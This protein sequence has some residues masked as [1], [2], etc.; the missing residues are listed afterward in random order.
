MRKLSL[1]ALIWVTATIGCN[2][3]QNL[4]DE[5]VQTALKSNEARVAQDP[6]NPQAHSELAKAY[7]RA[8]LSMKAA[9][10]HLKVVELDPKNSDSIGALGRI[11]QKLG[12]YTAAYRQLT[13][14]LKIDPKHSECL[15]RLGALLRKDGSKAG[16][17]QSLT[18]W[19]QFLRVTQNHPKLDEVRRTVQEVEAQLETT[20]GTSGTEASK[21]APT[22]SNP[23]DV[24]PSHNQA[25]SN[26]DVGQ[27]NPF[28]AAIGKAIA[29]IRRKDS[30][31]AENAFRDALKI[32][33]NDAGALAGLAET[34][35]HQ[36]KSPEAQEAVTKAYD[37]DPKNTQ[38]QWVYGLIMIKSGKNI[39]RALQAWTT[40]N[41]ESPEFAKQVGVTKTLETVQKMKAPKVH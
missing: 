27:L 38:A 28:G 16:L 22:P 4:I 30:L 12:Y 33:P 29:A 7:D 13:H 41:R 34:L 24:I 19:R 17:A 3:D 8:G 2:F 5:A 31:A 37:A 14:C 1:G 18:Y 32:R 10:A 23:S 26:E 25:G 35:F 11:Y 20:A 15:Y 9:D 36:G 21:A 40:L 6:E 39:E